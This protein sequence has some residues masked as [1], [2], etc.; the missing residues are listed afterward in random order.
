MTM[1]SGRR[2]M[3]SYG[4]LYFP[5]GSFQA[6]QE[7]KVLPLGWE[8]PLEKE[9][10]AHSSIL[11]WQIPWTEEPGGRQSM[12]WQRAGHDWVINTFISWQKHFPKGFSLDF[13]LYSFR[14]N[15]P[16][17]LEII[18]VKGNQINLGPPSGNE[19]SQIPW[20]MVWEIAGAL[21]KIR[22]L[23]GKKMG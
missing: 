16:P 8:D 23:V 15:H 5:G 19:R 7:T 12:G 21:H 18:L 22:R 13:P 14:T 10:A 20:S 17:I 6:K 3:I 9:M 11:A 2:V 1:S 4:W